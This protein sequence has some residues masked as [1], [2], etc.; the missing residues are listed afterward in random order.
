[1][2][3]SPLPK[4]LEH[5]SAI[6]GLAFPTVVVDQVPQG[7][8]HLP[9]VWVWVQDG[10]L[11]DTGSPAVP[12]EIPATA[13]TETWTEPRPL[14]LEAVLELPPVYH[15]PIF[16]ALCGPGAKVKVFP[17]GELHIAR[18]HTAGGQEIFDTTKPAAGWTHFPQLPD[19]Y[20]G[21]SADLARAA[22]ELIRHQPTTPVL[23]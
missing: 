2:T 3:H 5:A 12:V 21:V 6:T 8:P 11:E 1:M 23:F 22:E 7:M 13:L 18:P 19:V 10:A 20:A 16:H 15:A 9:A 14:P 4:L 17:D